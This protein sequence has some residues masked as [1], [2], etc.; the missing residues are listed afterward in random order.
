ME[1]GEGEEG[2]CSPA[3][4]V[5]VRSLLW[6]A[7]QQ[8]APPSSGSGSALCGGCLFVL[9]D[10]DDNF[11]D[12][13][14]LKNVVVGLGPLGP[15]DCCVEARRVFALPPIASEKLLAVRLLPTCEKG[16]GS[17]HSSVVSPALVLLTEDNSSP[18]RDAS[19]APRLLKV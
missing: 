10:C 4:P 6:M 13:D 17:E 15:G 3:S 1:E 2:D 11:E 5:S 8:P 19:S 18:D 14:D 16:A 7:P 12:N 9:L